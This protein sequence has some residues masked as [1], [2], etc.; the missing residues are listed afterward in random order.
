ML[1]TGYLQPT[2]RPPDR[3]SWEEKKSDWAKITGQ[4]RSTSIVFYENGDGVVVFATALLE[5]H[6]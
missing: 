2:Q 6:F 5:N 1:W 4:K 3:G